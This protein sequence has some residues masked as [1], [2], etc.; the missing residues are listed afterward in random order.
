MGDGIVAG[1]AGWSSSFDV[2]PTIVDMLGE[3]P[4]S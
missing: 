4:P 3:T 1:D 2:V